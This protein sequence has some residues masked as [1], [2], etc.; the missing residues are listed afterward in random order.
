LIHA[1]KRRESRLFTNAETAK[2]FAQKIIGQKFTRDF[3]QAL[4]GEPELFG[5][6]LTRLVFFQ[7]LSPRSQMT[8]YPLQG[9]NMSLP[10]RKTAF[11]LV[12]R[13]D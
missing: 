7:L 5:K 9:V 2:N 13:S 4:L 6:Q 10:R 8:P 3:S 1:L 11:C 12:C